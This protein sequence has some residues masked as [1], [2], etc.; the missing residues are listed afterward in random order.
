MEATMLH[1]PTTSRAVVPDPPLVDRV[2]DMLGV[3]RS[4]EVW[5]RGAGRHVLLGVGQEPFARLTALG[6]GSYGLAFQNSERGKHWPLLLV[7]DL[8]AVVEHALIACTGKE[9]DTVES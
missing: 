9:P 4:T 3:L 6:G 8:A 2:I 1:V 5:A 7:D